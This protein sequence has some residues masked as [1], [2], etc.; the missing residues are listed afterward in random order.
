MPQCAAERATLRWAGPA[1]DTK[2]P[3]AYPPRTQ[4]HAGEK[5]VVSGLTGHGTMIRSAGHGCQ[6]PG[7]NR[8]CFKR[9]KTRPRGESLRL[10]AAPKLPS[11]TRLTPPAWALVSGPCIFPERMTTQR[12]TIKR[13]K[14][15]RRTA[16]AAILVDRKQVREPGTAPAGGSSRRRGNSGIAEGPPLVN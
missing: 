5:E 9:R 2:L 15:L 16:A 8:S 14:C 4:R 1:T 6:L 12:S 7:K 3:F 11:A 13:R 10:R